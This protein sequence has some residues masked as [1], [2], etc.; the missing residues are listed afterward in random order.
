MLTGGNQLEYVQTL[1]LPGN[2]LAV[3]VDTSTK[4]NHSVKSNRLLVSVDTIHVPGSTTQGR[5]E[6]DRNLNSLQSYEFR[7]G[8]LIQ[9]E[10][11][12]LD[13]AYPD[14]RDDSRIGASLG[15]SNLLYNLE[16]MRK[17]EGDVQEE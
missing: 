14:D 16:N 3:V 12:K 5:G 8:Q 11:F 6:I 13:I 15:L 4:P 2:A 10:K 1:K 9:D 17:R 7:E